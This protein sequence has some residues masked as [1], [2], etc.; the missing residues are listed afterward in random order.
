MLQSYMKKASDKPRG[1]VPEFWLI[2][3]GA[4]HSSRYLSPRFT[5]RSSTA[6]LRTSAGNVVHIRDS[7]IA[8]GHLFVSSFALSQL[9]PISPVQVTVLR[10]GNVLLTHISIGLYAV[11]MHVVFIGS[12][13]S[14]GPFMTEEKLIEVLID[15]C[16]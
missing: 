4:A 9:C 13:L 16:V 14:N 10:G 8:I 12:V 15:C 11:K 5:R 1:L 2:L 3:V 6:S 7:F